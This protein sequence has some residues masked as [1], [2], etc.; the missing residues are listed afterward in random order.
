MAP[1]LQGA[2]MT[3]RLIPATLVLLCG[4]YSAAATADCPTQSI[5]RKFEAEEKVL[6]IG[7]DLD[8]KDGSKTFGKVIER[9][10]KLTRS[11]DFQNSAGKLVSK[12][13]AKFFSLGAT[14]EFFDCNGTK[15]GTLKEKIFESLFKPMTTYSILDASGKEIATSEKMEVLSTEFTL[16]DKQGADVMKIKRP[17]LNVFGDTWSVEV[18]KPGAVDSRIVPMIPAF[19][20]AADNAAAASSSRLESSADERQALRSGDK[21]TSDTKDKT[22]DEQQVKSRPSESKAERGI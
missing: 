2:D 19:K 17:W 3:K 14:V 18:F 5:P 21:R 20:T 6:A 16:K 1:F 11:F 7:T 8:L 12:G 4:V 13:E 10:L 9:T 22:V 15:I